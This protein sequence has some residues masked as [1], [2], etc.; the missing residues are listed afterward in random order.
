MTAKGVLGPGEFAGW[1]IERAK[2][3]VAGLRQPVGGGF[4]RRAGPSLKAY[5]E[6]NIVPG[7]V[8]VDPPGQPDSI[9]VDEFQKATNAPQAFCEVAENRAAQAKKN[10]E[11]MTAAAGEATH[12]LKATYATTLQA[13]HDYS[14]KVLE[15]AQVNTNSAFEYARQMAAAESPTEF[16]ELSKNH[17]R[18]Q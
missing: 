11:K 4:P 3:I 12:V 9:D 10:F 14:A 15:F 1:C 17:L 16:F 2:R 7:K 5:V 6:L 13:A 18:K 8:A